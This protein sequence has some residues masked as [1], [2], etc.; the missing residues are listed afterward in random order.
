MLYPFMVSNP[1]ELPYIIPLAPLLWGCS[2]TPASH[3]RIP[4]IFK[5]KSYK[6][7]EGFSVE[8]IFFPSVFNTYFGSS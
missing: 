5:S 3:P 6:I 7:L 8:V 4:W 1:P 2:P